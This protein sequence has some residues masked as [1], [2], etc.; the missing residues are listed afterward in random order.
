MDSRIHVLNCHSSKAHVLWE[1]F[2]Q[3]A[4]VFLK[5]IINYH[6]KLHHRNSVC[7]V[8]YLEKKTLENKDLVL[9]DLAL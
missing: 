9:K 3:R 1:K 2:L 4:S 5:V 8:C 7:R 6:Y